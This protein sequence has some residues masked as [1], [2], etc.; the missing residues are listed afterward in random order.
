MAGCIHCY[1]P[2]GHGRMRLYKLKLHRALTIVMN[3]P[4]QVYAASCIAVCIQDYAHMNAWVY[5]SGSI[6]QRTA[7]QYGIYIYTASCTHSG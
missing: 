2:Y 5:V 6:N 4:I 7:I 1:L 3:D